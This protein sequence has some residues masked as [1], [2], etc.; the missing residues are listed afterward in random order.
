MFEIEMLQIVFSSIS[1]AF[2][3]SQLFAYTQEIVNGGT[4]NHIWSFISAASLTD[5]AFSPLVYLFPKMVLWPYTWSFIALTGLVQYLASVAHSNQM[6]MNENE[7]DKIEKLPYDLHENQYLMQSCLFLSKYMSHALLAFYFASL[8]ACVFYGAPIYAYVSFAMYFVNLLNQH[9]YLPEFLKEPYLYLLT[10]I[11]LL[12][13][14]GFA[15]W[16]GIGLSLLLIGY[17]VFDYISC[18]LYGTQ[19]P[20]A[21][22]PMADS[23]KIFEL[24]TIYED[25]P[26]AKDELNSIIDNHIASSE[27]LNTHV[28]FD[29][30]Y[31][32]NNI[33]N[34]I[35]AKA[36]KIDYQDYLT[37]FEALNFASPALLEAIQNEMCLHDK[38][39]EKSPVD[40]CAELALPPETEL[41]DIQIA[42]LQREMTYLV[43]RLK[44]PSYKDLN[45]QQMTTLQRYARFLLPKIA[46]LPQTND[47]KEVSKREALLLSLAT[48]TGSHC[49][50]VYLDTFTELAAEYDFLLED[51]A[52]TM[53]EKA[54][55]M[56]QSSREEA[57]RKYYYTLAKV[58]KS[59][60][61]FAIVWDDLNDYHTYEDFANTFGPNFY[62]RNPALTMRFRSVFDVM[63]D[64]FLCYLGQQFAPTLLFSNTYNASYLVAQSVDPKCKL[65]K[66]FIAWCEEKYP[67]SYHSIVYYEYSM[68]NQE[69]IDKIN[70]LAELMLLDYGILSI[71]QSY[72][73]KPSSFWQ[74]NKTF[75]EAEYNPAQFQPS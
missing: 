11:S 8:A 55:L 15:S 72:T 58:A 12:S 10:I 53:Q 52:L 70:A 9:G 21:Q 33:T 1:D 26:K 18:Y 66:T 24:A 4:K 31:Q 14:F 65:H 73:A 41:V 49:N 74:K 71:G 34:K 47:P 28:T 56:A 35:L 48:R 75:D 57:F 22:F 45:H 43:E 42:Y 30:F 51:T 13:V 20:T 32:S 59:F 40:R 3:V 36:P 44:H 67:T 2:I 50:R 68:I 6:A 38:F 61:P 63:V 16:F 37:S 27:D 25:S 60:P 19:S 69:N 7:P 29:H 23:S 62:L 46:Q 54:V 64:R 39:N 5:F 17:T